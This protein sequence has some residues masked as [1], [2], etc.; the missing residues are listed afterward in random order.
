MVIHLYILCNIIFEQFSTK[1]YTIKRHV[2]IV[3]GLINF[4]KIVFYFFA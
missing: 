2:I 3:G 1:V 4:K